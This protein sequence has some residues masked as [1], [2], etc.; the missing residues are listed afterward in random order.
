M[1]ELFK[2][3]YL[4]GK[5]YHELARLHG[6]SENTVKTQLQRAKEKLRKTLIDSTSV[7]F[8]F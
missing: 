1:A 4:D 3:K 8:F 7:K 5:K 2:Q 6:I